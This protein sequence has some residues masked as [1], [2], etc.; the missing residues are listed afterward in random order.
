MSTLNPDLLSKDLDTIINEA[1]ALKDEFRKNVI[2]PELVLLALIRR[3]KTAARRLLDAFASTR[4]VDLEKLERQVLLAAQNRT[5]R[6][7]NLDFVARGNRKVPLS[8]QTVILLDDALSV[9]NSMHEVRIDTDHVLTV[10]AEG[11]I[12]TSGLLRQ[13]GITPKAI[14]DIV[15]DSSAV[16]PI[17]RSS[18]TTQDHVKASQRGQMRAVYFREDLLREMINILTQSVNRHI[19]LIGPDGVGKRTLA[20]SLALL[21]SEGKGPSGLK[22]LV[23]VDETALL[24]N[25]LQA[26]RAGLSKAAGGI[27]FIP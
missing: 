13:Y 15:A 18:G 20:Y 26:V 1:V 10:L 21:M 5:D 27:L 23:Q 11:S 17:K 24:D 3:P 4:G 25:D 2:Y 6:N 9:A 16:L 12:S 14:K 22:S 19:I 8:R 7:G